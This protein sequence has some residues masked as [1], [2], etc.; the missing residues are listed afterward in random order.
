MVIAIVLLA[1]G[2]LSLTTFLIE[3]IRKYSV[4]ETLI[5]AFTSL[6][7]IALAAY[8]WF[9]MGVVRTVPFYAG[10]KSEFNSN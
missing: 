2:A 10:I 5:K 7:F 8:S 9:Q 3:K 1:C 6:L 4:K